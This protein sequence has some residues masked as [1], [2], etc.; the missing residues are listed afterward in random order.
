[1]DLVADLGHDGAEFRLAVGL[2]ALEGA[3]DLRE[4]HRLGAGTEE[5]ALRLV[6]QDQPDGV[7]LLDE[8][9][10]QRRGERG[11][12]IVLALPR[13]LAL[14]AHRAAGVHQQRRAE[15]ALLLV[16]LD[17]EPVAPG[18]RAPV[19]ALEVIPGRVLAVVGEL[20]AHAVQRAAVQAGDRALDDAPRAHAEPGDLR[21]D[22][23]P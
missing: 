1:V 10:G 2:G 8:D 12:V 3:E 22:L 20:D 14:V 6:G 15:V 23:R 17:V 7:A 5:R 21:Q 16:P 19:E 13:G 11:G 4:L 9:G 18:V